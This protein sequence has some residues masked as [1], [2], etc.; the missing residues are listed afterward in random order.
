MW[1]ALWLGCTS[2][3]GDSGWGTPPVWSGTQ[4]GEE[5]DE[6]GYEMTPLDEADPEWV[7]QVESTLSQELQGTL[8]SAW[9]GHVDATLS[10]EPANGSI[11]YLVPD[12]GTCGEPTLLVLMDLRLDAPPL[13]NH[14]ELSAGAQ[15]RAVN[16]YAHAETLEW[17]GALDPGQLPDDAGGIWLDAISTGP[18]LWSVLDLSWHLQRAEHQEESPAATF[19]AD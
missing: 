16:G 13:L 7:S 3:P 4:I 15:I 18:E 5:G 17:S 2:A 1:I 14:L 8:T 19:T 11:Q 9:Q 10:F 6:C 12:D